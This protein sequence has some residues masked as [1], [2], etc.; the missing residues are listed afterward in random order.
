MLWLTI[1]D[2]GFIPNTHH[3]TH[4]QYKHV[5]YTRVSLPKTLSDVCFLNEWQCANNGHYL[6]RAYKYIERMK[7]AP[8]CQANIQVSYP[9]IYRQRAGAARDM[10]EIYNMLFL[11]DFLYLPCQPFS[12]F[13][14]ICCLV[15]H[16]HSRWRLNCK[17][18]TC[19]NR[20][21]Q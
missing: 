15:S 7:T 11:T 16:T 8:R 3:Q 9:S 5:L 14:L 19:W 6:L 18:Q 12:L 13:S 17:S 2:R 21:K 20:R 1:R 4:I 10:L